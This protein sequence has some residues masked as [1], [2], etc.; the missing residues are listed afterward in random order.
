MPNAFL[1]DDIIT[2]EA[3][4]IF[5][6]NL[7]AAKHT[8]NRS[9][10]FGGGDGTSNNGATVRIRKPNQ[11]TV[12]TTATYS[13]SDITDEYVA[14]TCDQQ[15]GVDTFIT[16]ADLA[17]SLSDFSAQVIRPQV[18][19]LANYVDAYVLSTAY[20]QVA[21]S[22]GAP[23]TVPSTLQ[24]YLDAG[25]KLDQYATPRDG[26]R[27]VIIG[28]LMQ[29]AIVGGLS[30]LFNSQGKIGAQYNS[31]EMGE[32]IGFDWQMDQNVYGHTVGAYAG[33]PAVSGGSQTGSSLATTGG[34]GTVKKGDVFTITGV[35][36]VNPVSKAATSTLQQ[37]TVTADQTLGS[38]A[39]IAIYPPITPTGAQ[40]TV[41]ASPAGSAPITFVGAASTATAQG[42]AWHKSAIAIAFAPLQKPQGVDMSSVKTDKQLGVSMRFVRWYDGDNDRFKSRFDV[43]FG[44]KV[45]RPE[46]A[47]RIQSG[48]A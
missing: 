29:A 24:V 46:W 38:P 30:G 32:A 45:V 8:D 43:L 23:G 15:I 25:A 18:T 35:Y 16:S 40:K 12:R 36:A 10:L 34:T 17:L 4:S 37:F 44:V 3:L 13:A 5:Q 33:S 42:M 39:T 22:V 27:S 26:Q 47:V 7:A 31:G 11:Y 21:N 19:L 9:S 48:A 1:T 14:L 28:P 2:L 41:S 20:Q 6:N